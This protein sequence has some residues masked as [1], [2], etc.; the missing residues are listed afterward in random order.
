MPGLNNSTEIWHIVP[1]TNNG[2][3]YIYSIYNGQKYY[4]TYDNGLGYSLTPCDWTISG[5][6]FYTTIQY[7]AEHGIDY[8]LT[9]DGGTWKII[10][11]EY[12]TIHD[13]TSG[14]YLFA[15]G[16]NTFSAVNSSQATHFYFE[17]TPE[18]Q[19]PY[20]K[21]YYG[22]N[23]TL[24]FLNIN[25]ANGYGTLQS[26]TSSSSTSWI[27][28]GTSIRFEDDNVTYYLEYNDGWGIRTYT[29]AYYINDGTNYLTLD[30][31]TISNSENKF[32]ATLFVFD[33]SGTIRALGT[34]Y[35]LV[36]NNGQLTASTS[37]ST[38][39]TYDNTSLKTN[40]KYLVFIN[41]NWIL[42]DSNKILEG[43]YISYTTGNSTYY[44]SA[45]LT[46]G[47]VV[48]AVTDRSNAT[49]W[50]DKEHYIEAENSGLYLDLKYN[51]T[52]NTSVYVRSN[53]Y[54]NKGKEDFVN[55]ENKLYWR[56]TQYTNSSY[57]EYI[58][59]NNGF[60]HSY[61]TSEAAA[62]SNA[63]ALTFTYSYKAHTSGDLHSSFKEQTQN[64]PKNTIVTKQPVTMPNVNLTSTNYTATKNTNV[65]A[66][67]TNNYANTFNTT[68]QKCTSQ[69]LTNQQGGNPTYFPLRVEQDK[70]THA[71]AD[72]YAAS[73]Y[74]TGYII[75]GANC[76]ESGTTT[77]G[78]QKKWGDIRISGFTKDSIS[79]SSETMTIN[80]SGETKTF[81]YGKIY[82]VNDNGVVRYNETTNLKYLKALEQFENSLNASGNHVFGMH[83]MDA[84]I[85]KAHTVRAKKVTI[86]GKTY[87]DYELPED[88]VDFHVAERGQISFFAG[89]YF[90]GSRNTFSTRNDTFFSLNLIFR[91]IHNNISEILQIDEIYQDTEKKENAPYVYKFSN[92]KYT[93][94]NG[95]YNLNNPATSLPKNNSNQTYHSLVFKTS[96]IMHPPKASS[97]S[98]SDSYINTNINRLFYFG[99]PCNDG[100]YALGSVSG[101]TGAYLCYLDIAANGG[102]IAK[103]YYQEPENVTTFGVDFRS[104]TQISVP[105]SVTVTNPDTNE[106]E[107]IYH[108]SILQIG[109]ELQDSN[110]DP[111]KLTIRVVFDN[112]PNTVNDTEY[113]NGLYRIYVN[114]KTGTNLR[115]HV[116]LV[117]DD[118]DLHNNFPYA[119]QVIYN[120]EDTGEEN[121]DRIIMSTKIFSSTEIETNYWKRMAMFNIPSTGAATVVKSS[122]SNT[123]N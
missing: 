7:D 105:T 101:G 93:D 52:N 96:W 84:S 14:N 78:S 90:E 106:T 63:T 120:N 58:H 8:Y 12:Y 68:L 38:I 57:F 19:N 66:S 15:N 1:S 79:G 64:T 5:N 103:E 55:Y 36:N 24:Y 67:G 104:K 34:N 28:N 33:A 40:N 80:M 51:D 56:N 88:S 94:E 115:L 20:G 46:D 4:L 73:R 50:S 35:Y 95:E 62:Q 112:S 117:D 121:V 98:T 71:F 22:Y 39:W 45:N 99:I 29:D 53:G 102:E 21:I 61:A 10:D 75:S 111:T 91:D 13:Q 110:A 25:I 2:K 118:D 11:L 108:H 77:A 87:E 44:M 100:E 81:N 3:S 69:T 76:A 107:T 116:L 60:K 17:N 42:S 23:G 26:S 85:S 49:I 114:N 109:A 37:T 89:N 54:D 9:R 30:G 72:G 16:T 6:V 82:T 59:Y 47:G 65:T 97:S 86:L 31:T 92:G 113:Q 43:Y 122:H 74:N 70:T 119:Y 32:S 41:D 27:N 83:F 48:S 18:N 123:Q